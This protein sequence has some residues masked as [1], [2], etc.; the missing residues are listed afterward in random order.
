MTGIVQA[1]DADCQAGQQNCQAVNAAKDIQ[2]LNNTN[3]QANQVDR[4]Q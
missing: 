2:F 3:N 4:I 1:T